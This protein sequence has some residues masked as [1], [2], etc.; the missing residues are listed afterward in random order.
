MRNCEKRKIFR[1][2]TTPILMRGL[3]RRMSY[4]V[5]EDTARN[6]IIVDDP[7]LG[8]SPRNDCLACRP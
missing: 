5:S 3:R 8:K 7:Y 4:R 1:T 6:Q 2:R